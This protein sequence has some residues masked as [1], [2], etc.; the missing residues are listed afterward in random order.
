MSSVLAVEL[1]RCNP[2]PVLPLHATQ[3]QSTQ[4]THTHIATRTWSAHVCATKMIVQC[5]MSAHNIVETVAL[6]EKQ[7]LVLLLP[8][9]SVTITLCKHGIHVIVSIEQHAARNSAIPPHTPDFL[10][11]PCHTLAHAPIH[12]DTHITLIDSHAE[13]DG[14]AHHLHFTCIVRAVTVQNPGHIRGLR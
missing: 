8:G 1:K 3:L 10:S 9:C 11:V 7:L 4:R 5:G 2:T 13:G 14:G 12:N 6:H